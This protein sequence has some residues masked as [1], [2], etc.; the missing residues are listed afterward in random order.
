MEDLAQNLHNFTHEDL[1]ILLSNLNGSH[2]DLLC[3]LQ[4]SQAPPY[5]GGC[6]FD[7]DKVSCWPQTPSN[8]VA[9]QPCFPLLNGIK[10]DTTR[11]YFVTIL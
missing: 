6:N 1:Q 9:V 3:A 5:E 2:T 4:K 11:K 7:F 8:S 10:Y